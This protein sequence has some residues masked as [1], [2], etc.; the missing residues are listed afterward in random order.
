MQVELPADVAAMFCINLAGRRWS[1]TLGMLL[2]G[3]AMVASAA[4]PG[5]VIMSVHQC[6]DG[7]DGHQANVVIMS[8]H[9][10]MSS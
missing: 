2:C 10:L 1:V 5:L 8:G 6:P 3:L 9:Q 4:A 7:P